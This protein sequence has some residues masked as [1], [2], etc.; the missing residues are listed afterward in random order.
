V[1]LAVLAR[2]LVES[3]RDPASHNRWPH[4]IAIAAGLGLA[5]ALAGT[6]LGSLFL[7]RSSKRPA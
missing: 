2:V 3:S 7:L 1:P 5:C 6:L 4:E